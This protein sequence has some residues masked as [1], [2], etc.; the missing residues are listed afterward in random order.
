[1]GRMLRLGIV[2]IALALV[3]AGCGWGQYGHDGSRAGWSPADKVLT[4]DNVGQLVTRWQTNVNTAWG[5][6]IA[7]STLF[8]ID[9]SPGKPRLLAYRADGS[10]GCSGAPRTC[11]PIWTANLGERLYN[12]D[13]LQGGFA[14]VAGH[15]YVA[16]FTAESPGQWRLEVFDANGEQKC[17][18]APKICAPLWHATWGE[19]DLDG[20]ASL[21]VAN[22]KVYVRTPN[23]P[24]GITVFDAAGQE[25]CMRGA[26]VTCQALF[27]APTAVANG[28]WIAVDATRLLAATAPG[29]AVYDANGVSG[30]TN[31]VCSPLRTYS[32][33]R[34]PPSVSDGVAFSLFSA[35]DLAS[36]AGCTGAPATC[37][38]T[39]T[40]TTPAA[41]S[42]PYAVADGHVML[43]GSTAAGAVE[44]FDAHGQAGCSGVPRT[45]SAVRRYVSS[46][47]TGVSATAEL[48]FVAN[49]VNGLTPTS[50]TAFD[51]AGTAGC[52]GSTPSCTPL[53][54]GSLGDFG[55]GSLAPPVVAGNLVAVSGN[56]GAVRVFGLAG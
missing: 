55:I 54:T 6:Q 49:D 29:L 41:V 13:A 45:C 12:T 31:R 56:N 1:M 32:E 40:L 47:P 28:S 33:L 2:G 22:G 10:T 16:G 34:G 46:N 15:V 50:V 25:R 39:W 18:G 26:A 11:S 7:D 14:I 21:A 52:S 36:T 19:E 20:G 48:V 24:Q 17:G 44:V 9:T 5:A 51:L 38:P 8:S 23:G 3:A 35:A 4:T 27:T 53:W 37:P 42:A 43:P 30:C